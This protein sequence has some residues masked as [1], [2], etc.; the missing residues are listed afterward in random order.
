M[1]R[2]L[3]VIAAVALQPADQLTCSRQKSPYLCCGL[4]IAIYLI[5]AKA[6]NTPA[7]G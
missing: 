7:T 4:Y 3:L 5:A 6:I 1:Q 2:S